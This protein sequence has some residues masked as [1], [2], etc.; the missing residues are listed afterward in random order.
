M[1][2][3]LWRVTD[4]L[5]AAEIKDELYNFFQNYCINMGRLG[6]SAVEHLPLAWGV[7]PEY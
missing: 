3:K 1:K 7:S 6:G 4:L 2:E 5:K